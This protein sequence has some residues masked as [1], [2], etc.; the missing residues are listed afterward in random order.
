MIDIIT[1]LKTQVATNQFFS[2]AV[3]GG[4]ILG[5]LAYF[6][7]WPKK[8]LTFISNRFITSVSID[9]SDRLFEPFLK[10]LAEQNYDRFAKNYNA[11]KVHGRDLST[12]QNPDNVPSRPRAWTEKEK[13]KNHV[14]ALLP[15]SGTFF[16]WWSA[17]FII[18]NLSKG[19]PLAQTNGHNKPVIPITVKL[20]M[21]G[22]RAVTKKLLEEIKNYDVDV[23]Q[24][25]DIY[26]Y[27][28][29]GED[30]YWKNYGTIPSRPL[31]SVVMDGTELIDTANDIQQFMNNQVFYF[32][33]GIPYR[34]GY[35]FYGPAGTGK[36]SAIKAVACVANKHVYYISFSNKM[37]DSSFTELVGEVATNSILVME[38]VDCLFGEDRTLKASVNFSTIL[39][40]IDGFLARDGVIL[41]MT[42]NYPEKLDSALIR[43][44]RI[45]YKV[46]FTNCT[47]NQ[48][49][50]MFN[51]FY[52]NDS[53]Y[54]QAFAEI[55]NNFSR[56]YSPAEIQELL[57]HFFKK[58]AKELIDLLQ[59]KQ[60]DV[61]RTQIVHNGCI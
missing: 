5:I 19:T 56:Q 1:F 6:R 20:T 4:V 43:A 28:A 59:E 49:V 8:I 12:D 36:T 31:D 41:I 13:D 15:N 39:N 53:T 37:T 57:M 46:K 50:K 18:M 2:G 47:H 16:F 48:L 10:W 34:R 40:T 30:C 44:G 24:Q 23:N 54:S 33:R 29:A 17:R 22:G 52:P 51:K 38:D 9:N 42:T 25:E 7:E 35:L 32:E 27:V 21:L 14:Y 55:I 61:F 58:P 11:T 60:E 3:G 45:D 26:F